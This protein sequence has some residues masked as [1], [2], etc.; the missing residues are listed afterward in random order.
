MSA[1]RCQNLRA[2]ARKIGE[3]AADAF[4]AGDASPRGRWLCAQLHA[5]ARSEVGKGARG[6]EMVCGAA[7]RPRVL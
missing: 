1:L 6:L 5:R 4:V 3:M 2:A 7:I